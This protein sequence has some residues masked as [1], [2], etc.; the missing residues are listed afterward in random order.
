MKIGYARVSTKDQTLNL[1]LDALKK[2]GCS[3]IYTETVS[4]ARA[5]RPTGGHRKARPRQQ[6]YLGHYRIF[7]A[8]LVYT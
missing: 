5:E 3:K 4:G 1:Q 7:A 8:C 2:A 6:R